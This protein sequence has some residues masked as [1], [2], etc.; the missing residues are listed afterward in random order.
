MLRRA[1]KQA[2]TSCLP[3]RWVLYRVPRAGNKVALTFD[4]G[5]NPEYTAR[6]SRLLREQGARA[7]FFLVGERMRRYRTSS[8]GCS[9]TDTSSATIR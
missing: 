8:R 7:T 6:V 2:V 3:S 9:P 4:D 1:L 5:P